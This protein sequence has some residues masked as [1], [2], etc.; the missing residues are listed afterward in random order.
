MSEH[1]LSLYQGIAQLSVN[2][3]LP[4]DHEYRILKS[5]E[6]VSSLGS[7]IGSHLVNTLP[8]RACCT[9]TL[10]LLGRNLNLVPKTS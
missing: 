7:V 2:Q 5:E 8:C 3:V 1:I 9:G 4:A 10:R 6:T